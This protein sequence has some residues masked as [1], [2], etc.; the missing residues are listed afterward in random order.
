MAIKEQFRAAGT[1]A[2][3]WIFVSGFV[4]RLLYLSQALD[5]NELIEE[6]LVDRKYSS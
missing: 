1:R 5:R 3:L 2:Y 6:P 4:L